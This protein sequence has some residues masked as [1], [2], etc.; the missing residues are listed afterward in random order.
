MLEIDIIIKYKHITLPMKQSSSAFIVA[1]LIAAQA[2]AFW[3][4]GHLLVARIAESVLEDKNPSVLKQALDEL[5]T[6]THNH[7][8]MIQHERDHP[9]TECATFADDIKETFGDW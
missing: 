2:S 3:G 4:K 8:D 7:P 5:S 6:L 9:F 1:A